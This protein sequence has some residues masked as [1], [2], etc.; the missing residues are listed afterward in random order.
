MQR[1]L[2]YSARLLEGFI[3]HIGQTVAWLVLV[4]V[5]VDFLIVLLRYFFNAGWI[6]M[7][8]SV[9]YMHSLVFL[10]G[11]AY[12]MKWDA[13][14]RVDILYR[15]FGVRGQAW[16]DL[17]GGLFLLWPVCFFIAWASWDYVLV[18][19]QRWETSA[20]P[21]GLPWVYVLKSFI[22]VFTLLL[23]LQSISKL[24][25]C[26]LVLFTVVQPSESR[27]H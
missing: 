14:V 21:G 2:T 9:L 11:A 24:L 19:W 13:H 12:T 10:L 18:S 1:F 8:E 25:H 22:M 23:V 6:A 4:R 20:D 26:L 17:L 27:E 5:V 15:R 3:Q 7:Q 16:V